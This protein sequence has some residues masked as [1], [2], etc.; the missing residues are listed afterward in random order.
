M[1]DLAVRPAA[2]W[3]AGAVALLLR[4]VLAGGAPSILD[5]AVTGAE[6]RTWMARRG[7]I[8][9]V[10]ERAGDVVGV[11][12]L[13]PHP[14]LPPGAL[15]VA[16]FVAPSEHGVGVGSALWAASAAAARAAGAEWVNA[17]IVARNAGARAFYR[18]RGFGTYA[19]G[20]GRNGGPDRISKRFDLR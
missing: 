7:A 16:T 5:A 20:P 18:S 13:E 10:A 19:I 9:H 8:W 15:D 4:E 14:D 12:W 3:D 1:A 11:Q 6:L 17:T 2:P